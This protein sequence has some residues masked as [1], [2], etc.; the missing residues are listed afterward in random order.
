MRKVNKKNN[1]EKNREL[2]VSPTQKAE[3]ENEK[4]EWSRRKDTRE[5]G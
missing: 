3:E 5:K 2:V 1:T 4:Q